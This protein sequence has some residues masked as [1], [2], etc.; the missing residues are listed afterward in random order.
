MKKA[1]IILIVL[2]SG[3]SSL[4]RLSIT[5]PVKQKSDININNY[6]PY[7]MQRNYEF[8]SMKG[9]GNIRLKDGQYEWSAIFKINIISRDTAIIDIYGPLG[10]KVF[11]I[12]I[13]DSTILFDRESSYEA[14]SDLLKSSS[15]IGKSFV[16]IFSA[17]PLIDT[18][19][20]KIDFKNNISMKYSNIIWFGSM[21]SIYPDSLYLRDGDRII[22]KTKYGNIDN[23]YGPYEIEIYSIIFDAYLNVSFSSKN[24]NL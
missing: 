14:I 18:E 22:A 13:Q 2:L 8:K 15:I 21:K 1:I 5:S 6:Y 4:K 16:S 17:I 11:T 12:H 10:M 19:M 9:K 23:I 20:V 24:Y 7:L 3:C